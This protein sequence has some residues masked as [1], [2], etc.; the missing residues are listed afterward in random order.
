MGGEERQNCLAELM[1]KDAE[2]M[3][4]MQRVMERAQGD[5]QAAEGPGALRN[6]WKWAIRKRIWDFMEANDIAAQ[7]RPVHNRI[8]NFVGAELTAKHAV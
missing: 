1:A 6:P 7:P 2:A 3:K 8:P 5:S 4:Q